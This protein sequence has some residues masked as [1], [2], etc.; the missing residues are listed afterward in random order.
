MVFFLSVNG[1]KMGEPFVCHCIMYYSDMDTSSCLQLQLDAYTTL[2]S[3]DRPTL[4]T[5]S[6][7]ASFAFGIHTHAAALSPKLQLMCTARLRSCRRSYLGG[8]GTH[9]K[10]LRI[11]PFTPTPTHGGRCRGQRLRAATSS[12]TTNELLSRLLLM[13]VDSAY[14]RAAAAGRAL[15]A[16]MERVGGFGKWGMPLARGRHRMNSGSG[17]DNLTFFRMCVQCDLQFVLG[18]R[19]WRFVSWGLTNRQEDRGSALYR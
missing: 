13:F 5:L 8:V 12:S 14:V 6:A 15:L 17:I 2:C 1:Y 3:T 4:P 11:N 19:R 9:L 16:K 18:E 7:P 10:P